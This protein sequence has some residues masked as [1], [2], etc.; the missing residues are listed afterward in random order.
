LCEALAIVMVQEEFAPEEFLYCV[1]RFCVQKL[2][3][4]WHNMKA[5]ISEPI[6][7]DKEI[8]FSSLESPNLANFESFFAKSLLIVCHLCSSAADGCCLWL[9]C[10]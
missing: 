1:N 2:P 7:I 9:A 4:G 5:L 10:D 3:A 6:T 8:D